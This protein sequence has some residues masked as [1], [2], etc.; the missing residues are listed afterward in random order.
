MRVFANIQQFLTFFIM[1]LIVSQLSQHISFLT[2]KTFK[3]FQID[4]K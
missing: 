2:Q 3:D 1:K 4:F